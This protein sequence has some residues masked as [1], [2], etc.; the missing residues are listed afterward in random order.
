MFSIN[1]QAGFSQSLKRGSIKSTTPFG[2]N[3]QSTQLDLT[4]GAAADT[5]NQGA[6]AQR[7]GNQMLEGEDAADFERSDDI[8]DIRNFLKDEE[9]KK[10]T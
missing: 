3:K 1:P 10:Q 9:D 8:D 2:L 4:E 6:E 7:T 5:Q